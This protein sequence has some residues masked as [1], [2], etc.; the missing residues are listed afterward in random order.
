[1]IDHLTMPMFMPTFNK[2][3]GGLQRTGVN[4]CYQEWL[5]KRAFGFESG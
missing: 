1:M 2:A 4:E 5:K 3:F